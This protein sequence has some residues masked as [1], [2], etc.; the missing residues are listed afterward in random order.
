VTYI[1]PDLPTVD[2]FLGTAYDDHP[3]SDLRQGEAFIARVYRALAQSPQWERMVFVLTFD[4]HGGFYDHVPPPIVEDDTVLPT[5]GPAPDL[6][7]L[8][9]RVPCIVMGPLAPARVAH[10]GPY[11]HCSILR[12]IEW[13]WSLPPMTARD[14]AAANLASVLDFSGRRRPLELAPIDPGPATQC[15]DADVKARLANGGV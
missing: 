6:K 13:R 5:P 14:R 9:F 11:E 4:E 15:S 7:R 3:Y 1:D 2:E 10:G 12:M 8:G